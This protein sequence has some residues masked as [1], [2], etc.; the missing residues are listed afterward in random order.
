[1]KK[2]Q[3]VLNRSKCCLEVLSIEMLKKLD[4]TKMFTTV[5]FLDILGIEHPK[6]QNHMKMP[7]CVE[8]ERIDFW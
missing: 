3:C 6:L 1:M 4:A 2:K 5:T 7:N 8:M